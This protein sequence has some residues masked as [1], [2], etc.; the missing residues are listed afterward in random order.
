MDAIILAAG[1]GTRLYPLTLDKPK[2]L[3]N[4]D[5]KTILDHIISNIKKTNEI[6]NIFLATNNKFYTQF[7]NWKQS[8]D[9]KD[10]IIINDKTNTPEERLGAVGDILYVVQQQDLEEDLLVLGGDNLFDFEIND[11]LAE[12]FRK[13]QSLVLVYDLQ[14]SSLASGKYGVIEI[15]NN[16][17]IIGFEE[18]PEKP[19]SSLVST[20]CYLFKKEDIGLL[21]DKYSKENY[22]FD[23]LGDFV[24]YLSLNS[25]VSAFMLKGNWYDIGDLETL[26]KARTFYRE[27]DKQHF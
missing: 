2:P 8:S 18:K 27:K 10:I 7:E 13:K 11:M 26:K 9:Y 21:S 25:K 23:N 22:L 4:I 12:F 1:Y 16:N 3:L 20:A 6:E 14:D 19:K 17:Q 24:K 15:D 5:N